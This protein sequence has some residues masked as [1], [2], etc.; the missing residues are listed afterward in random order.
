MKIILKGTELRNKDIPTKRRGRTFD[1]ATLSGGVVY[2]NEGV[3]ITIS[4]AKLSKMLKNAF[5][6]QNE[7]NQIHG[8]EK[9]QKFTRFPNRRRE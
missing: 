7:K 4:N 1:I 9:E 8:N 2:A 5:D 3:I 6:R